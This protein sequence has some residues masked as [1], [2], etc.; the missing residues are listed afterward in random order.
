MRLAKLV[1]H[2]RRFFDLL[3]VLDELLCRDGAEEGAARFGCNADRVAGC[4]QL[5]LLEPPALDVLRDRHGEQAQ[6]VEDHGAVDFDHAA[7]LAHASEA[8]ERVRKAACSDKLRLGD[9]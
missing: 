7:A 9:A 6:H 5:C 4:L 2:V 8:E 1:G 3:Q